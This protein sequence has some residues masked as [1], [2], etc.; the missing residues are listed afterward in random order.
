MGR[1][2]T[3]SGMWI[4][5]ER[6][7]PA[8]RAALIRYARWLRCQFTFPVRVPVYLLPS[9]KV[10]TMH[11]ERV[12]ASIFLPWDRTVE[13]YIRIATGDFPEL[14]RHHG[15]D[16]ALAAFLTSLSHEVLHHRQWIDTGRSWER[17]VA[18]RAKRLVQAYAETVD[19]P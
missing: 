13:P 18:T 15:R 10:V 14:C 9:S 16:N 1:R 6:G 7:H 5:G 12:S 2:H 8:V 19:H 3:R 4:R 11:G 17:G